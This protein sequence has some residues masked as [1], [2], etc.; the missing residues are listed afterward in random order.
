M[1]TNPYPRGPRVSRLDGFLLATR[2]R[3]ILKFLMKVAGEYGDI[4][5]F[6]IGPKRIF[7]LNHPDYIKDALT[8]HYEIFVKG[9]Q[10]RRTRHFLGNGLLTSEGE[11]HRRQR[12]LIQPEFDRQHFA[13]HESVLMEHGVR[14]RK[15]W[16][17][18]QQVDIMREMK[19]LTLAITSKMIFDTETDAEANDINEA[20]ALV[21]SQFQLFGSQLGNVLAKL[22][23]SRARRVRKAQD[24]LDGIVRRRIAERRQSGKDH[25]DLL[26]MLISALDE[27]SSDMQ[28]DELTVRDEAVTFFLAG[29]ETMGTALAWTWFLLAQDR[30][31]QA[32]LHAELDTVLGS[33]LPALADMA[34]L[35]YTKMVFAEAMRMYPPAWI[36]ARYLIKDFETGGY[37]LPAGS[38]V[39]ISQYLMHHDSRYFPDPSRF[40]PQRWTSELKATRPQYS[41]FPFGG[42]PRGCLG[43]GLAWIQGTLLIATI[44]QQWR[45]QAV[46][47][48]PVELHPLITLQPKRKLML[49]LAQRGGFNGGVE[50]P[51]HQLYVRPAHRP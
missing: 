14:L 47:S 3:D 42:G 44:A 28:M 23:M 46:P 18:G 1:S 24:R 48:P 36:L 33:R 51:D 43:E 17:H 34:Q 2:R 20:V 49:Q 21:I 38:I 29:H 40:D 39:L 16:Q 35:R 31:V 8:R 9:R 25:G 30:A 15:R 32:E 11:F 50:S 19:G 45:V 10:G 27:P 41:Y 12:R 13:A 6:Q 26:S 37:V 5:H 7:L 22:P 4:A